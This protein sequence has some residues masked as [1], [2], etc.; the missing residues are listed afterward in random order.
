MHD[1]HYARRPKSWFPDLQVGLLRDYLELEFQQPEAVLGFKF[2]LERVIDDFVLFCM[3][4]GND[5]L[6]CE[7]STP[8][9]EHAK[10]CLALAHLD[11]SGWQQKV[12]NTLPAAAV[13]LGAPGML[14][15]AAGHT[16]CS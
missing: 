16:C 12:N 15:C 9:F 7:A 3:L 8:G 11:S 2:D 10:C 13:I 14:C 6:P 5:F 1:L 4:I